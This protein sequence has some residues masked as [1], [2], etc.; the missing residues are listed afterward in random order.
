MQTLSKLDRD[1]MEINMPPGIRAAFTT[2]LVE[3]RE[4]Q[5]VRDLELVLE[6][7]KKAVI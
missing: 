1:E 7:K 2:C 6:K 5:F 3:E 4:E